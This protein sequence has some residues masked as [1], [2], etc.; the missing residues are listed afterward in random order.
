MARLVKT[1]EVSITSEVFSLRGTA[2]H[3]KELLAFLFGQAASQ[4]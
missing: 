4:P 3:V 2:V 1:S